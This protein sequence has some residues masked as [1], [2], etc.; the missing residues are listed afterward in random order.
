MRSFD[1]A[2]R[3]KSRVLWSVAT[4]APSGEGTECFAAE[5]VSNDLDY[6][7]ARHS[8]GNLGLEAIRNVTMRT[9]VIVDIKT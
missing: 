2:H 7:R 9:H 8:P 5:F 3:T 6:H 4:N 1:I